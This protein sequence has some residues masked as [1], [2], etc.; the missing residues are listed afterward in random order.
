MSRAAPYNLLDRRIE[1]ELVP[2]ASRHNLGLLTWS[3][4][5]SGVLAGRYAHAGSAPENSRAASIGGYLAERVTER[6]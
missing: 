3:P 1:N 4:L 2:L 5:A 6:V